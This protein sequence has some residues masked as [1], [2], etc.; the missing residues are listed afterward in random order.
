MT[1]PPVK[2]ADCFVSVV[3][4][5]RNDAT[6]VEAFISEVMAVLRRHYSN[7]ELV[8]VDDGSVDDTVGVVSGLL[9]EYECIRL[10]RLSRQ[11]G[12]EIAI[13]A[14]LDS[15]IGDFVV[16]M[17]P[18][19]DPPSL[20]PPAVAL[21]RSG[22]G[23]VYGVRRTRAGDSLLVRLGAK[24]FY[25]YLTR[26][27]HLSVPDNASQFRVLSRQAVNAVVRNRDRHRSLRL[28]SSEIGFVHAGIPYDEIRRSRGRK[29]R[30]LWD[31]VY[32]GIDVIVA[33]SPHPLRFVSA[34]GMLGAAL[35]VVYTFYIVGVYLIKTDVPQGWTTLS[36]QS[37]GMFL[38]V[39]LV[40]TV[41]SEYI[42]HILVE[43]SQRPLYYVLEERNSPAVVAARD[44]RNL[45][46]ESV[47]D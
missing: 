38:L 4:P 12:E 5:L 47:A 42:G 32:A 34:I 41:L 21:A 14:G 10:V 1:Q 40:L 18:N 19:S 35:N 30:S 7:Y 44:R 29:G 2:V 6:I 23:V 11:F 15:V 37:A 3:A 46:S 16:I 31:R 36:L 45:V 39:C 27:L 22:P 9:A 8:V 25:W 24:V 17:L 28:V 13:A 26:L 33:N 20:I 43:S